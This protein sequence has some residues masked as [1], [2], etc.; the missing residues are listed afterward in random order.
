[1]AFCNRLYRRLI[2]IGDR[3]ANGYGL[4]GAAAQF[5]LSDVDPI[6]GQVQQMPTLEQLKSGFRN[7][8]EREHEILF[9]LATCWASASLGQPTFEGTTYRK[10]SDRSQVIRATQA[11]LGI[12]VM[13]LLHYRRYQE[14][15][16]CG[17]LR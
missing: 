8:G 2:N 7:N 9:D 10:I 15:A 13:I 5:S 4:N 12:N 11:C 3:V 6:T 14:C 17:A 1:M 16:I